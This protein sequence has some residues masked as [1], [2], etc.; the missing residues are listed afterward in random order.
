MLTRGRFWPVNSLFT[1]LESKIRLVRLR[2]LL[3]PMQL[4]ESINHVNDHSATLWVQSLDTE[5][6]CQARSAD[7]S[8]EQNGVRVIHGHRI[9][10]GKLS[11]MECFGS[12][13]RWY[14]SNPEAPIA[15]IKY[16]IKTSSNKV[17]RSS[18]DESMTLRKIRD[19]FWVED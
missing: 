9:N 8:G 19:C 13:R 16:P 12:C 4:V 17:I 14:R 10:I 3:H 11:Q 2:F 1:S 6:R 5:A 7:W 18:A 15:L